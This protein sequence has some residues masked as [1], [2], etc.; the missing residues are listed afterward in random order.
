M[1]SS[2]KQHGEGVYHNAKGVSRKATWE[3]GKRATSWTDLNE[4]VDAVANDKDEGAEDV[5][6][7]INLK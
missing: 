1:W 2:G 7:E 6:M 4:A 5:E 3:A